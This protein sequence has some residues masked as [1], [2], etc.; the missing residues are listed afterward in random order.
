MTCSSAA[1]SGVDPSSSTSSATS[2]ATPAAS[3][4]VTVSQCRE[5]FAALAIASWVL[6]RV[7]VAG[8]LNLP[9]SRVGECGTDGFRIASDDSVQHVL[10]R[11]DVHPG[12]AGYEPMRWTDHPALYQVLRI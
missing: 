2:P 12:R 4:R 11:G 9:A 8:D 7:V 10:Y 1:G 6:P 3:Q 5:L